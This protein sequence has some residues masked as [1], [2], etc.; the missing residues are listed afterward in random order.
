MLTTRG[1]R[2]QS[3]LGAVP[4]H[5]VLAAAYPVV[6]LFAVNAAEQ[7]T[8]DPLWLPLATAVAA[9]AAALLVLGLLLGDW[10]RA[11]LLTTALVIGFFGYGHAWNAAAAQLD[12]QWPFIIA[13]ALAIGI[14]AFGAWRATRWAVPITR[15]LNVAIGLLLLLNVFSLGSTMVAIGADEEAGADLTDLTLRPDDPGD[16][17]DVYYIIP[18]RYGSLQTLAEVYG[19]DNE[20]FLRELESRGF[21]VARDA[22]ANYVKT[23][24][25][26]ASV[27]SM[28]M[29]D[30][31]TL[32]AE[33]EDPNDW[34]PIYERLAGRQVVPAALKELGYSYVHLGN[35]WTPTQR[36]VD[37]DRELVYS[38]QDEFTNALLQTTLVRALTDPNA[39]PDDPWDWRSMHAGNL[40]SL[41]RLDEI[42]GMPGPKY[43]FAHLT[44]PHPPF[45]HNEDGSFT[46]REQVRELGSTESY[47]R[48]L[49]YLNQRL[50]Q[51]V[52]R[53]IAAD[54]DAII[55]LAADEGPF[56]NRFNN[57]RIS[58]RTA[59]DRELEQKFGT[60]LTM[61]VPGADLEAEGFHDSLTPVNMFRIVFNARF[62]T[63]LPLL[64]DTVWVYDTIAHLYEM[65]EITDR[66]D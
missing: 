35:W 48:Q 45:V 12:T 42:P 59:T 49:V 19:H 65:H 50:L 13:W 5:P 24:L 18:D 27:L 38:G 29:L 22:H 2:F 3:G 51:A 55:V 54:P 46:G 64:P 32:A 21:S 9:A 31:E 30:L 7:L 8:L 26:L 4:I 6:F 14:L 23:G 10:L 17:P 61:R 40:W 28:D 33:A 11:G 41:D 34:S 44:I 36:N 56:P 20:P 37:A 60:L 52:D 66:F 1:R 47:R 53:I 58:W 57:E 62:G 39:A 43:V 16:L 63:D 25:S 15:F